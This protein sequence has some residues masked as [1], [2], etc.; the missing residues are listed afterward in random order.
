MNSEDKVRS[1]ENTNRIITRRRFVQGVAATAAGVVSF[2][3]ILRAA[4]LGAGSPSKKLNIAF[5]GTGGRAGAHVSELLKTAEE[6]TR[7]PEELA[8]MNEKDRDKLERRKT[9]TC[10]AYADADPSHQGEVAKRAPDAKGYTDWREMFDNHLKDI[11]AVIIAIPDHSH[12]VATLRAIREGKHVYCEKPLT[13]GV[14]EARMVAEA[15]AAKKV[16]TQMGNQGHSNEGNRLTVEWIRAGVIGDVQEIHTWTNR[17]VWPQG[18]LKRVAAAPPDGLN[19]DVWLGPAPF[20]EYHK[21][22][23]GDGKEEKSVHPFNWRGWFDFGAG[24]VGD[25]GCHT[26]DAP[27]W[28]MNPDYPSAV[29]LVAIDEKGTESFPRRSHFKWEFPAKGNRAAFVAHWYSGGMKPPAP[30]EFVNDPAVE[31]KEGKKRELPG[32]GSLY[33]GTKGKLLVTGDYGDSPRLIPEAAM[34]E[35]QRPEKTIARSPG[36]MDEWLMACK[37]EKPWDFPGSN[38]SGYAGPL[39]EV[40]LL[41]TIAERIGEVGFRI[42]CDP[43]ARTIKTKEA[44]AL[45]GREPRKGWEY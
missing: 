15:T 6:L 23:E 34:K 37:E 3:Y 18:N 17:P 2:P 27:F 8:K 43:T 22:V 5:I 25:M 30:E 10:V 45:A 31:S 11:D 26:W 24:A 14:Q 19:W 4:E 7:T 41:G 1:E 12:A 9:I 44:L 40:M 20:R 21:F 32:S 35:F 28:A 13:W 29:E 38:F 42:E 33:I 36:H 39:T 16:A